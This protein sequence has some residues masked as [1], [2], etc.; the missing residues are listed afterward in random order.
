MR[1]KYCAHP[2]MLRTNIYTVPSKTT[3]P[4][5]YRESTAAT[6]HLLK[7]SKYFQVD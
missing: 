4:T 2:Q 7:Q 6:H 3:L 5:I 1:K